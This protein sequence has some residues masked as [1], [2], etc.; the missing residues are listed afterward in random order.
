MLEENEVLPEK[1]SDLIKEYKELKCQMRKNSFLVNLRKNAITLSPEEREF[2]MDEIKPHCNMT[3]P[4]TELLYQYD[5]LNQTSF[6]QYIDGKQDIIVIG[7]LKEN[8]VKVGFYS[9][10]GAVNKGK[11]ADATGIMFSLFPESMKEEGKSQLKSWGFR[12]PT[13]RNPNIIP[14]RSFIYDDYKL[15]SG[16]SDFRI[17]N[18]SK[19]L[20]SNFGT[21]VSEVNSE[22]GVTLKDFF[23]VLDKE[24]ELES[25]EVHRLINK[26]GK[27]P[28][29]NFMSRDAY[30]RSKSNW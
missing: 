20:Y 18:N 8:G 1:N 9:K 30:D 5:P 3:L 16:N 4:E 12:K 21:I 22:Q 25:W 6:H 13:R 17:D 7:R 29:V 24:V 15:I 14:G 23:G 28:T 26:N 11:K 19:K 2:L 10:S 27:I